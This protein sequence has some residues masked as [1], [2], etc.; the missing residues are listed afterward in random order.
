MRR[1]VDIAVGL[2]EIAICRAPRR[3]DN[4]LFRGDG[5]RTPRLVVDVEADEEMPVAMASCEDE[6]DVFISGAERIARCVF[7]SRYLLPVGIIAG[8]NH[9]PASETNESCGRQLEIEMEYGRN[10]ASVSVQF[11]LRRVRLANAHDMRDPA[12]RDSHC[13]HLTVTAEA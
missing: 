3:R 4:P 6:C 12:N 1:R 10:G 7:F 9:H 11:P 2:P 13:V 5:E 8:R